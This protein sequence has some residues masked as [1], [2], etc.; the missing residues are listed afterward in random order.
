MKL[1]FDALRRDFDGETVRIADW[2][3][4]RWREE[5]GAAP[6]IYSVGGPEDIDLAPD[7]SGISTS[8]LTE[9]ALGRISQL[10]VARGLRR[11]IV[12]GGETSGSV[13][14]ALGIS[15]FEVDA[16]LSPGIAW[17][18]AELADGEPFN[19]LLKSGGLGG[20]DIFL[21]AW[22]RLDALN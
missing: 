5:P 18:A 9:S 16:P 13:T 7:R 22:S 15:S 2:A 11:L 17:A 19:I 4:E 8:E 1:D 3:A 21:D 14:Q 10:L 6:L 20:R 12:A